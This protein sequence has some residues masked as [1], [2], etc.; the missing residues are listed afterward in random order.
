[1][2]CPKTVTLKIPFVV[3]DEGSVQAWGYTEKGISKHEDVDLGVCVD[4]IPEDEY[5]RNGYRQ[6]MIVVEIPV[7]SMFA[8]T[9]FKGK[10][11]SV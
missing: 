4:S 3:G 8:D 7:A 5:E 10:I 9:E 6:G 1:M 2:N 11:E